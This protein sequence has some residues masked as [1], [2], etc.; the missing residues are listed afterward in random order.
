MVGCRRI[1]DAIPLGINVQDED[2]M[3]RI[4]KLSHNVMAQ[5]AAAAND[6]NRGGF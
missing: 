6:E 3:M 4:E 5:K 2:P 1:F